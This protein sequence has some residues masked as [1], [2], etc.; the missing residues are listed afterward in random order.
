MRILIIT[1]LYPDES[2]IPTTSAVHD[3]VRFWTKEHEVICFK[4]ESF[5]VSLNSRKSSFHKDNWIQQ[6][7]QLFGYRYCERD[8]VKIYRFNGIANPLEKLQC[9]MLDRLFTSTFKHKMK[10][11]LA[12]LADKPDLVI[13]HYAVPRTVNYIGELGITCPKIAVMHSGDAQLLDTAY[14]KKSYVEKRLKTLNNEFAA[15]FV[16]SH[17][18]YRKLYQMGRLEE[19]QHVIISSG[20]PQ[21]EDHHERSWE[22]WSDREKVILYVGQLI[23][24]KGADVVLKCLSRLSEYASF[25]LYIVGDGRERDKLEELRKQSDLADRVHMVGNISREEVYEYMKKADIFVMPSQKETV[26][27]VYL[28]AMANGCITIGAR[29]EG[30]DGIIVNDDNGFLVKALDE[31]DLEQ[32]FRHIFGMTKEQLHAM[33][34]RARGTADQYTQ[35]ERSQIYLEQAMKVVERTQAA[36]VYD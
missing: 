2:C 27:L 31:D 15:V 28:E 21:S 12:K 16:R 33:S 8:H 19:L 14:A 25:N 11:Q 1:S 29:D 32:C 3:L 6:I 4:E 18:I 34:D 13:V 7:K 30:M 36:D 22:N 5:C 20:V 26:G 9:R 23:P 10:K 17:A 35:E 24:R